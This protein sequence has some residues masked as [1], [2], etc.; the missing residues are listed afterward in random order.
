MC[1]L[2]S[3]SLVANCSSLIGQIMLFG[4]KKMEKLCL[5]YKINVANLSSKITWTV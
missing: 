1:I 5:V 2:S 4:E 3:E